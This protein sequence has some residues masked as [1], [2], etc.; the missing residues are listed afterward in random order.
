MQGFLTRYKN[1]KSFPLCPLT[2]AANLKENKAGNRVKMDDFL[3]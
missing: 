3:V 2:Y 1:A